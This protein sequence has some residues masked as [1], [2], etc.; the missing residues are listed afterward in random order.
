MVHDVD[1]LRALGGRAERTLRGDIL[2]FESEDDH[3]LRRLL[4]QLIIAQSADR[5][6]AA[7]RVP[8]NLLSV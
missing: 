6:T 5:G 2:T 4:D 1:L 8:A 3:A 7:R